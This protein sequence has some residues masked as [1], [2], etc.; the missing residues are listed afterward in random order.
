MNL[1]VL[2]LE[3]YFDADYS[4]KKLST[5]EYV[6]DLRFAIHM[7]GYYA[8]YAMSAPANCL[9]SLLEGERGL[10][11]MIEESAVLCHHAQFDLLAL[12]R[13]YGLRPKFIFDTLSMA[14]LVLP[15]L[16]S[17]SLEALAEH[18]GL[19]AKNVPYNLFR[20]LKI[21]RG[22][23]LTQVVEGCELD[24]LLTYRIFQNLLPFV[25]REELDV[26]DCT[27]RMFTEPCLRLDRPRMEAFLQAE[28]MRKGKAML[29]AAKAI[30]L[31]MPATAEQMRDTLRDVEAE[32]QSSLKF[33]TALEALGYKC[34]VKWSEKQQCD[35]PALAKNDDGM[36]ELLEHPDARVQ[37]LAAARLGVKSTTDE[38]RAQRLLGASERGALPVYLSYAAAKTLR[39]G[40]GDKTNWQNFRR[41]GEIRKSILAPPGRSL[42]IGD[43][44]QIEYR[45]LCWLA[46]Q[47]DKLDALVAGRD[48][49][50]EFASDFYGETITKEDKPRRGVGKQGIL[51]SGYGAGEHTLIATAAGGGYGPPVYLTLDEGVRM[52]HL[53]RSQHP[54]VTEFWKWCDSALP[55][56]A[57]GGETYYR[58]V[59]H[60]KEHKIWLPNGTA[61][62]YTG[63][64]WASNTEIFPDQRDDGQGYSWWEPT[65]RGWS[66][67]W[68]SKLTADIIQALARVVIC[69]ALVIVAKRLRVVLQVHDEIVCVVPTAQAEE[70]LAWMLSVLKTPPV[71]A[72]DIP[73]EAEGSV[74]SNYDK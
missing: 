18:Y 70:A 37:A 39:F 1:L 23:I 65:R 61:I 29:E 59:L 32:L 30:G 53:F 34:P 16:R 56:L 35:I 41:G 69:K 28:R 17:H 58:D 21:L 9:P 46:G 55:I 62:D 54:C 45:L 20:G 8:P 33:Q 74:S 57:A 7:V 2:D 14:R 63:L 68:G 73:L 15:K 25:P 6:R 71:W 36:E 19:P 47:T 48:L 67:L 13:W 38:T 40:G 42:V 3:T 50:C 10:R 49:Y 43:L 27:V 26:I 52:K 64:R 12:N 22:D 44:S 5:E 24:V 66:R 11:Q 51:M 72:P 4:L 60:I 31:P